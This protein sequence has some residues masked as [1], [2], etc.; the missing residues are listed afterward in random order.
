MIFHLLNSFIFLS[1][2]I[3]IL[4]KGDHCWLFIHHY[5]CVWISHTISAL[6]KFGCP[7]WALDDAVYD[8]CIWAKPID[9]VCWVICLILESTAFSS[10]VK[11]YYIHWYFAAWYLSRGVWQFS[12]FRLLWTI[13]S[14]MFRCTVTIYWDK[15]DDTAHYSFIKFQI[16]NLTHHLSYIQN[17]VVYLK[18]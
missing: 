16:L 18:H 14:P 4:E 9:R 3:P 5:L 8:L 12:L 15:Y 7:S 10:T 17:L 11:F 2:S 6:L 1:T 13:F